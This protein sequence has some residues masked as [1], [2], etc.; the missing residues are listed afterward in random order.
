MLPQTWEFQARTLQQRER[1]VAVEGSARN[2]RI[3][4]VGLP[5]FRTYCHIIEKIPDRSS[6]STQQHQRPT[7][8]FLHPN[9]NMT[10]TVQTRRLTY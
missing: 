2:G 7:G 10:D 3:W 1:L 6:H 4:R 5:E 9:G 8:A